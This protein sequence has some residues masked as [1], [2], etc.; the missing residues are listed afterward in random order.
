MRG[1]YYVITHPH[2]PNRS[3]I[4][5]SASHLILPEEV[6]ISPIWPCKLRLRQCGSAEV[7]RHPLKC[8]WPGPHLLDQALGPY[9]GRLHQTHPLSCQ[10]PLPIL[11]LAMHSVMFF[12]KFFWKTLPPFLHDK[13]LLCFQDLLKYHH[14]LLLKAELMFLSWNVHCILH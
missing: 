9:L 10:A 14:I 3:Q 4:S 8:F 6:M 5:H 13:C 11:V 12:K 7:S 1:F 2:G